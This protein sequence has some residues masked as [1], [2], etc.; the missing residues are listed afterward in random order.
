MQFFTYVEL[1]ERKTFR[2]RA[3]HGVEASIGDGHTLAVI[4]EEREW[5]MQ[6]SGASLICQHRKTGARYAIPW[7]DVKAALYAKDEPE[8]PAAKAKGDAGKVAG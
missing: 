1:K 6:Q 5:L 7:S 3:G 8:K 2:S 4:L